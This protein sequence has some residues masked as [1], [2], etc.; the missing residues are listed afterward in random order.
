MIFFVSLSFQ[1]VS[2]VDN[3]ILFKGVE[4]EKNADDDED[5]CLHEDEE[6]WNKGSIIKK[7]I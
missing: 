4:I 5:Q 2:E 6:P 3:L 7:R 1:I